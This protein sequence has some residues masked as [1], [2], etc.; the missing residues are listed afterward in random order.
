MYRSGHVST[1]DLDRPERMERRPTHDLT[2][3]QQA[4]EEFARIKVDVIVLVGGA[5]AAVVQKVTRTIPIVTLT[6][7]DLVASGI[8]A[9]LARPA[10]NITGMQSYAP[11]MMGK[12][13]QM[14]KE[15]IPTLSRVAVH[16]PGSWSPG[17]LAVYRQVTDDA[18]KKLGIRV[19][20]VQFEKPDALPGVFAEMVK[21]R[22]TALLIWDDPR[23]DQVAPQILDLTVKH[24][25]PTIVDDAQWA[26]IGALMAYGPKA[27][28]LYW[29]AAT[30]YW[31]AATHVD[32]ILRGAKPADLP[33]GQPTT[34]VLICNLKTAK[35]LGLTLPQAICC[36]QIW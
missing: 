35:A 36:W 10:G 26:K 13:L 11:E 8:V 22:D 19:R 6:S 31:Q 29:Q 33:I 3:L 23:V 17:I 4:A 25:I 27:D 20:D 21:E 28:D 2:S 32:R 1:V 14:L 12:R 18:A 34:F 9:S 30:L 16:R 15:L 5:R 24:R 7:G